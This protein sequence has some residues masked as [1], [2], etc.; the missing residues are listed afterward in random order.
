MLKRAR[1]IHRTF[2]VM[3]CMLALFGSVLTA[4]T[5]SRTL[6]HTQESYEVQR[7]RAI[8]VYDQ[9]KFTEAVPLFEKLLA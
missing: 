8:Q 4:A 5:A 3:L 9:N 1:D 6:A 2:S 7:Q